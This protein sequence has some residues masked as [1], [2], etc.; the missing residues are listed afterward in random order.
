MDLVSQ[1]QAEREGP[2]SGD[3]SVASSRHVPN[4]GKSPPVESGASTPCCSPFAVYM[5]GQRPAQQGDSRET[6]WKIVSDH[7]WTDYQVQELRKS[8]LAYAAKGGSDGARLSYDGFEQLLPEL[9]RIEKG[10]ILPPRVRRY[11]TYLDTEQKGEVQFEDFFIWYLKYMNS[12]LNRKSTF[13]KAALR[14][15]PSNVQK[16][17]F[18][19]RPDRQS[20]D[21]LVERSPNRRGP[22]ERRTVDF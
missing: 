15:R 16:N 17:V 20:E 14:R 4:V 22:V 10:D 5:A 12:D 21:R 18:T 8:F 1:I 19:Q 13:A 7:G 3:T 9:L 6:F 11:W 2:G